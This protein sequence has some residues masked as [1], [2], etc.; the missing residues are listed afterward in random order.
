[1]GI[2]RNKLRRKDRGRLARG[3]HASERI[4]RACLQLRPLLVAHLTRRLPHH[5]DP[6]PG[7]ARSYETSYSSEVSRA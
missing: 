1:M 2:R 5:R 7:C 3:L 6:S 4:A